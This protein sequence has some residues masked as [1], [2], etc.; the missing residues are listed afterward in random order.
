MVIS[1]NLEVSFLSVT[2]RKQE[3]MGWILRK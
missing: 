2:H 3:A 1:T